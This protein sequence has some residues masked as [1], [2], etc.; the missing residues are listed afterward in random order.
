MEGRKQE[1]YSRNHAQHSRPVRHIDAEEPE[2]ELQPVFL[3]S[4][5][6]FLVLFRSDT[7]IFYEEVE[8]GKLS[9]RINQEMVDSF[10][11]F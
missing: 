6:F 4:G 8:A 3:G 9:G 2:P 1:C 5:E 11:Y 7:P 10:W